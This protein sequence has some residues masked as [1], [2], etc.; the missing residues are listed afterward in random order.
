MILVTGSSAGLGLMA[1]QLLIERGH[2]VVLH[3]RNR[4][5]AAE[6]LRAA[7]GAVDALIGELSSLD[8][9]KA[10]AERAGRLGRFDAVIHNAAVGY[11]EKRRID[12]GNGLSHVFAVNVVA[13]YVLT[14]LM[15]RPGRL[16]WLGSEVHRRV[17]PDL[18]DPFWSRRTWNGSRAY[19]ESKF[20]DVALAFAFARRWPDVRS[21]AVEPGW[22]ATRMSGPRATGDLSKAHLTQVRLAVSDDPLALSTGGYFFHEAER[23]PN[24]AAR[25]EETQ[26][27]LVEICARASGVAPPG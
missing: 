4:T 25:L 15:D 7:P 14:A 2:R 13:P 24:P 22:V 6:A 3:G 1:A 23:A 18:D 19:A 17:R 9:T 12:V 10:L 20:H 26:E 21:N 27:R 16:V 5:R 11:K 8:E